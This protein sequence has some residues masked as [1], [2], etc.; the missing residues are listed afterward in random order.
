MADRVVVAA[1][2]PLF[3]VLAAQ[4]PHWGRNTLRQRLQLGCIEVNGVPAT[5]HDQPVAAGDVVAIVGKQDGRAA[6]AAVTTLPVLFV[7][8][9]LCAIDKPVGLLSVSSDDE[10]DRTALALLRTQLGRGRPVDL[11][12]LHR[13][14]RETSGVLLFART[15]AARAAVQARWDE[16][17]KVY[18]A[19]VVGHPAPPEGVIDRPLWEDA[20][21]RVHV[22]DHPE[23]RPAR[24]RYHTVARGPARARLAVELDTG[25]KHQIRAHL[26]SRGHAIVGDERYGTRD[27]RL[28]LHAERLVLPHPFAARTLELHAPVPR[29]FDAAL[30]AR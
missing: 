8:D 6:V 10:R 13:L 5:R 12:P 30:A 16:A 15:A 21:L 17:Q 20:N 3:T 7:D 19:V 25:R 27:Q 18:A 23:A 11:W 29:G 26:A 9:E 14:D 22:G 28:F 4:L 2:G 1:A 24:T